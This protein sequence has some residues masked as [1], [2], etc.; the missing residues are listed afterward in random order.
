MQ[1]SSQLEGNPE[2]ATRKQV[3]GVWVDGTQSEGAQGSRRWPGTPESCTLVS[4]EGEELKLTVTK[5]C[6]ELDED[7]ALKLIERL[8]ET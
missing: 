4:A 1:A 2:S 7:Q 5:G 3:P 6:P 8:E